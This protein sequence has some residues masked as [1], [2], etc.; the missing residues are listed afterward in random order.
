MS[1]PAGN[2]FA[3]YD[4]S[5][6]DL[7]VGSPTTVFQADARGYASVASS[8]A[9]GVYAHPGYVPQA[10]NNSVAYPLGAHGANANSETGVGYLASD[11]GGDDATLISSIS[12]W[13]LPDI[14]EG[15]EV[16]I[17]WGV[18]SNRTGVIRYACEWCPEYADPDQWLDRIEGDGDGT[19]ISMKT[20]R[21]SYTPLGGS[22]HFDEVGLNT[23]ESIDISVVGCGFDAGGSAYPP[24]C[25]ASGEGPTFIE[26]VKI[27]ESG[28]QFL[29]K[30]SAAPHLYLELFDASHSPAIGTESLG[31][32]RDAL[33][34]GPSGRAYTLSMQNLAPYIR[35]QNGTSWG[36]GYTLAMSM[37]L[38]PYVLGSDM[39]I[40]SNGKTLDITLDWDTWTIT[41]GGR[42]ISRRTIHAK[43]VNVARRRWMMLSLIFSGGWLYIYEGDEQ[44]HA[45][46]Q[47]YENCLGV[48]GDAGTQGWH[49]GARKGDLTTSFNGE[50]SN[51][52]FASP[53]PSLDDI[54]YC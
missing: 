28:I 54:G 32:S 31:L 18:P 30:G 8:N 3:R 17:R 1:V 36:D 21:F 29:N 42:F 7:S 26:Y 39:V 24:G 44:I 38:Q 33:V 19:T 48:F 27:H 4:G 46:D 34:T 16:E 5:F 51:L 53:A 9:R 49:V 6:R 12:G 2:I 41:L 47:G 37:L 14:L 25:V 50:I 20:S 23:E 11:Y 10:Y 15:A 22:D 45:N 13:T 52:F 35:K 40:F 43:S